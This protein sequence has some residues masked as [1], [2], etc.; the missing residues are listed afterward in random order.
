MCVFFFL[1]ELSCACV[2]GHVSES[3]S[4]RRVLRNFLQFC[5][6]CVLWSSVLRLRGCP[7]G[8][9]VTAKESLM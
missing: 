2:L 8:V 4:R 5:A 3:S 6:Q 1:V 7:H 9:G